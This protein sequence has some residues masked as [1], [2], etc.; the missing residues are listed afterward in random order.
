[1]VGRRHAGG[2]RESLDA[3]LRESAFAA[4][5]D[6]GSTGATAMRVATTPSAADA[7]GSLSTIEVRCHSSRSL[8]RPRLFERVDDYDWPEALPIAEVLRVKRRA[9]RVDR[10]LHDQGIPEREL[11]LLLELDRIREQF[12][13][14]RNYGP[15]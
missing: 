4:P 9:A 1:M 2:R 5:R 15:R 7:K 8:D 11:R 10:C 6:V 13:G 12:P 3:D 14:I